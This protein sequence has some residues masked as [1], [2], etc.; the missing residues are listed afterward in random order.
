MQHT[1]A[2]VSTSSGKVRKFWTSTSLAME[3]QGASPGRMKNHSL[4]SVLPRSSSPL[5]QAGFSSNLPMVCA[6][7]DVGTCRE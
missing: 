2:T 1:P 5:S 7:G 4:R 6:L 3:L